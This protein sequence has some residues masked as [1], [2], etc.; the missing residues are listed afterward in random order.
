LLGSLFGR[1]R[2][3]PRGDASASENIRDAETGDVFTVTG[4][5]LEYEDSYFM[6]EQVNRYSSAIGN[7]REVLG[8]DGENK[9]WV[10][11]SEEAGTQY[12]TVSPDDR[13]VGLEALGLAETD[14]VRLDEEQSISNYITVDGTDFYYR[15]SAETTLYEGSAGGQA[16]YMWDLVSE[17][18]TRVLTIDK[19]EGL[20]FR[21][22]FSDVVPPE[23]ITLY[24]QLGGP[25]G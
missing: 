22:R 16:F 17:D 15:F 2:K 4:H 1:K 9:V 25:D 10:S 5:A 18:D 23:S 13:P 3:K 24:K 21:A 19:W 8:A 14:M 11:W 12:V 7:W 20:P 6:V